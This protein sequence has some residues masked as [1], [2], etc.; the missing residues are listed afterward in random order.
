MVR[1]GILVCCNT[2]IERFYSYFTR[3]VPNDDLND[4]FFPSLRF[5]QECILRLVVKS[6]FSSNLEHFL[7]RHISQDSLDKQNQ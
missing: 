1:I 6:L 4:N 5:N 2:I 7:S 3:L